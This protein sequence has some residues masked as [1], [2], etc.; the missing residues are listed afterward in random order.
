MEKTVN[1]AGFDEIARIPLG[2]EVRD[3]ILVSAADIRIDGAF[4]GK[5]LGKGKVIFGDQSTFIG[6]LVCNNADLSGHFDGTIVVGNE[7]SLL[8]TCVFN[9]SVQACKIAVETGAK[10]NGSFKMMSKEEFNEIAQ[11][12]EATLKDKNEATSK[13]QAKD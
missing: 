5:I 2:V 9:G 10:M 6:D 13:S 4:Y 11:Q 8:N 7:L 3:A 12:F 1:N